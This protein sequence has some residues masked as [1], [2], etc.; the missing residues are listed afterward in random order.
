MHVSYALGAEDTRALLKEACTAT[1]LNPCGARMLR[2]GSNAVY[3]L[4]EP[5]VARIARPGAGTETAHRTV[6]V[7]RWLESVEYPAVRAI[8]IDQ[9]VVVDGH[10]VTFWEAISDDGSEYATIA[11]VAEVIARLHALTAPESLRLPELAPFKN[12][13]ERIASSSWLNTSDRDFMTSELARLQDEYARLEFALPHCVIHGADNI[14]NVLLVSPATP[15]LIPLAAFPPAPS[16]SH[17]L[18]PTPY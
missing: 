6:A 17:L 16:A 8:G 10:T 13:G 2:L 9:P 11:Q 14:V 15:L 5:V 3:R 18:Q 1:S 7:A 4:A 12:A